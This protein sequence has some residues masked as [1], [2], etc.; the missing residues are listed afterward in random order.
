MTAISSLR[1]KIA[2]TMIVAEGALRRHV[3]TMAFR[4][5]VMSATFASPPGVLPTLLVP[6]SSTITFGFTPSSS[7]SCNR[8]RMF[9]VPSAPHP[10]L[11]AFQPKKVFFQCA[12]SA[13]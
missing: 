5:R 12:S 11:P 4:P 6:A 3:S 8:H 10:K 9:W 13:G 7:P 1:G 2:V